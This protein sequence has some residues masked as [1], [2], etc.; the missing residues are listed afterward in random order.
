MTKLFRKHLNTTSL[1]LVHLF[2]YKN[3]SEYA[4]TFNLLN[5]D[6]INREFKTKTSKMI[7]H[8]ERQVCLS[9]NYWPK[10]EERDEPHIYEMRTYALKPGT[11]IEWGNN[12]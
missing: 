5:Q 12:W 2:R 8:R 11:L 7:R 10:P 1:L 3:Y 6:E 4:A 9:F